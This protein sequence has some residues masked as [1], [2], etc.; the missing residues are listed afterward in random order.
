MP[1]VESR[2]AEALIEITEEDG[3]TDEVLKNFEALIGIF[4]KNP[5][6]QGYLKNPNVQLGV[7]KK[8]LEELFKGKINDK[9][10]KFLY[11]LVDKKR[12]N[13]AKGILQEYKTL[14]NE[15]KNVLNLKIISAVPL[16]ELQVK[17]IEKK[18]S[19]IYKK[20][21]V[22]SVVH[23]DKSLIGGIKVQIGD[24]LEDYSVKSRLESLKKLLTKR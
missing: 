11:L 3:S 5:E 20:D 13:Y 2:Y 19:E 12:V 23:I 10:L 15:R 4:D 7:K 16:D 9:F 21:K 24:R 6:L 8:L 14:A 1:L 17:K 18:Y 22:S